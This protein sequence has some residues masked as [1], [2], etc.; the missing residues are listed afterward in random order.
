MNKPPLSFRAF[1]TFLF[2]VKTCE[3]NTVDNRSCIEGYTCWI[4]HLCFVI[5]EYFC[6]QHFSKKRNQG[7]TYVGS[8]FYWRFYSGLPIVRVKTPLALFHLHINVQQ[9]AHDSCIS[10][11]PLLLFRLLSHEIF[12]LRLWINLSLALLKDNFYSLSFIYRL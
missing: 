7:Y 2:C 6:F 1:Q 9:E 12:K 3:E 11:T 8:L 4:T 10:V 5:F